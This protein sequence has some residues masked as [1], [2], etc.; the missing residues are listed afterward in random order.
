MADNSITAGGASGSGG[1]TDALANAAITANGGSSGDVANMFTTLLVAQIKNQDPLSPSDPSQFVN[2]LTQMSQM[3]AMQKLAD[4]GAQNASQLASLQTFS[5]G[6]QVG[7]M[8]QAQVSDVQIGRSALST[9]YRLDAP[10]A[11]TQLVLTGADGREQRFALGAQSA[12]EQA[13]NLDPA[14]LGIASGR[15]AV[16]IE[17][18]AHQSL[19][20]ELLARLDSVRVGTGGSALLNLA[21]VAEVAPNAITQFKGRPS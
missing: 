11:N 10:S 5:L 16:R 18:E 15:Y 7:S 13:L 4:S 14:K 6:A 3:Q 21:G 17:N 2:Q 1:S 8:V 19:P 20:L 12:G 9:R